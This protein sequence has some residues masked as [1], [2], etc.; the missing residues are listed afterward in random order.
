MM[1]DAALDAVGEWRTRRNEHERR[2]RSAEAYGEALASNI[3]SAFK[4]Q[5][6]TRVEKFKDALADAFNSVYSKIGNVY[7]TLRAV[8]GSYQGVPAGA[9]SG[10]GGPGYR[11]EASLRDKP[12][13]THGYNWKT[14]DAV[15]RANRNR[16][17]QGRFGSKD[18]AEWAI[19]QA[20]GLQ[21]GE[22]RLVE[23]PGWTENVII[24]ADGRMEQATHV[25]IEVQPNK[26]G[27]PRIHA[28]PA[29]ADYNVRPR[30]K[31]N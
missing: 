7:Q 25:F 30:T 21:V 9:V 13:R 15:A 11:P 20:T 26:S 22:R 16:R 31:K 29:P 24:H 1:P 4:E 17:P 14:A 6:K 3:A 28:F 27:Q 2:Q 8:A 12:T 5:N 19:D 18:D 23:A 10:G